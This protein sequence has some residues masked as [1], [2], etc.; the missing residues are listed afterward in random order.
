[1]SKCQKKKQTKK[2]TKIKHNNIK[3]ITYF[4]GFQAKKISNMIFLKILCVHGLI[5]K[6][7][8][9]IGIDLLWY[10]PLRDVAILFYHMI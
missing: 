6:L 5:R 10:L 9:Q 7:Q 8:Y 3:L 4:P 1:M 2:P